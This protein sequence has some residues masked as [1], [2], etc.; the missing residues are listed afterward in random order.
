MNEKVKDFDLL[1][2]NATNY[3]KTELRYRPSTIN[4]HSRTWRWIKEFMNLKSIKHY[5]QEVEKQILFYRFKH[6]NLKQLTPHEKEVHNSIKM[7]TEFALTGN[8][9]VTPRIDRRTFVFNGSTGALMLNFIEY[10]R[11]EQRLS[12][13]RILCYER[14]LFHFLQ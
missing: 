3:L 1:V 5:T 8:I 2:V 7:M 13:S 6:R 4:R 12:G 9:K 11:T 14:Y 10:K